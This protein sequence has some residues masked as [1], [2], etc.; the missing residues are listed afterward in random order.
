MQ[1]RETL[2]KLVQETSLEDV[3]EVMAEY[4]GSEEYQKTYD[5]AGASDYE[6]SL[7]W[8]KVASATLKA[9]AETHPEV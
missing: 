3:L 8:C 5:Q 9:M 6:A 7:A 4:I 2:A 1:T